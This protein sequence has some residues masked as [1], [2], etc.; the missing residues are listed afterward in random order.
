MIGKFLIAV[1]LIAS[2][3][4]QALKV[5][6]NG[7]DTAAIEFIEIANQIADIL[8]ND[9]AAP[10]EIRRFRQAIASTEVRSTYR[11]L[12]LNNEF[13]D[14]INYPD[15]KLIIFNRR[16][17]DLHSDF[18]WRARLVMHEYLGIMGL[19]DTRYEL[20]S[21]LLKPLWVVTG[22]D[23]DVL[24]DFLG[25][26]YPTME[27]LRCKR[28]RGLVGTTYQCTSI[29]SS[30]YDGKIIRRWYAKEARDLFTVVAMFGDLKCREEVC[31]VAIANVHCKTPEN[32]IRSNFC[33]A[34]VVRD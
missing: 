26:L 17:W 6:G 22:D 4:A 28:L 9:P 21:L 3:F 16:S 34:L 15:I 12:V 30:F 33:T 7:G 19:E 13:K 14:A 24:L 8:E 23:A 20:S 5:I 11:R 31:T 1:L 29:Q 27:E 2:P 25:G 32:W 10:V 18:L